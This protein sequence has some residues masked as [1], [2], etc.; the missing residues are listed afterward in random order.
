VSAPRPG[1]S[2][3][4]KTAVGLI[5]ST[6]LGQTLGVLLERVS[7][8]VGRGERETFSSVDLP[9]RTSRRCFREVCKSGRVEGVRREGRLWV[10]TRA[11]WD[12]ARS[13]PVPTSGTTETTET[14]ERPPTLEAKA[15]ALL[16]RARLR[17]VPGSR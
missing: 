12:E 10:C 8:D 4:V 6:P 7:A 16:A 11:A 9:P 2:I 1:G 17:V 14:T 13:R 5:M 15:T 3:D